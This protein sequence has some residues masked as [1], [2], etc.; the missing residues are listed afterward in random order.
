MHFAAICLPLMRLQSRL[1]NV[2]IAV[3]EANSNT[4][5][6]MSHL[7]V[8]RRQPFDVRLEAAQAAVKEHNQPADL[9]ELAA[10]NEKNGPL[11]LTREGNQAMCKPKG[12]ARAEYPGQD[13]DRSW[14]YRPG[15]AAYRDF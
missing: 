14:R 8:K 5:F 3:P 2:I 11:C 15:K 9:I 13:G 7:R 12:K 1:A 4:L 10:A 6:A